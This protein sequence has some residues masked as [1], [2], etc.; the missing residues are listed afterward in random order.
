MIA[1][2]PIFIPQNNRS[3][4]NPGPT[5]IEIIAAWAIVAAIFAVGFY[6]VDGIMDASFKECYFLSQKAET[7]LEYYN[8]FNGAG[9]WLWGIK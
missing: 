6:I 3:G 1:P 5:W 7:H 8:V 4:N 9:C 2:V